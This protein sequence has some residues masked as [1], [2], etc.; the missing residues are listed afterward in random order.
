M[1]VVF[2]DIADSTSLSERLDPEEFFSVLRE[3]RDLCNRLVQKYGGVIARTVGDGLL[4]YFGLPQAHAD[5]PE[6]GVLA[7]LAI[8]AAMRKHE[9]ATSDLGPIRLGV[10]IG[11]NTGVLVVG[12]LTGEPGVERRDVFG[13]PVHIAARLQS[14]A[15]LNGVIIG[16]GTHDLVKGAFRFTRLSEQHIKGIKKP[17]AVWR[18]DGVAHTEGRFEKARTQPLTPMIGRAAECARLV[19]LWQ[20]AVAGSGS[21]AVVSG[22]KGIGKS[23]L[24]QALRMAVAGVEKE[25]LHFQCSPLQVNTPLAPL[26]EHDRRQAGI[27]QDD[28]PEEMIAKL[29]TILA[30]ATADTQTPIPYYG[31]LHSIPACEGYVPAELSSPKELERALQVITSVVTSLS[32]RRPVL[33]VVED[34]QWIDPT[35]VAL[36]EHL[37]ARIDRERLLLIISHNDDVDPYWLAGRR[38][39]SLPLTKLEPR[40][41]EKMVQTVAG[42]IALPRGVVR[43]ILDRA[44]GIPLFIEACTRS[45]L[46]ATVQQGTGGHRAAS[47]LLKEP[48]VP[49]SLHDAIMERLDLLGPA[50][51]VAQIASVFGRQFHFAGLRHIIDLPTRSLAEGLQSLEKAGLVTRQ[52]QSPGTLFSFKHAMIQEVAYGSLLKDMRTALHA[53]AVAWLRQADAGGSGS[54]LAVLGYHYSR[55]GLVADAVGAWLDAGKEALSRSASREAIANLWEG[56][57]LV[58]KLPQPEDRHQLELVLQA[59]LGMAYTAMV[60]WAGPQ[61]DQPYNRALELCRSYGTAREK[62]I[63]LWGV[64]IAALVNSQLEK[65][66][67]FANEFT[68]LAEQWGDEEALLMANATA[69]LANFFRGHLQQAKAAARLICERYDR[70]KHG[71]LVQKCQHDP[72]V[73]SLVYLGHIEWLLGNPQEAK[74]AC[75]AARQLARELG[76][77]FMLAFALILGSCDHLYERNHAANLAC[78]EEG[79]ELA[80]NHG[81]TLYGSFGPLW[82]IPA[83][84][85]KDASELDSLSSLLRTLLDNHYYLQAPLYQ[86]LLAAELGRTG[87]V[88]KGRELARAAQALMQRTGER[89]FEPEIYRVSGVLASLSPDPDPAGAARFFQRSLDSARSLGTAGWELRTAVSFARALKQRGQADK[90]RSLLAE[91]TGKFPSSTA[92]IDLRRADVLLRELA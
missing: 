8:A 13:T 44:D 45:V 74:A 80:K 30:F 29:H 88:A 26:I 92:S 22:G 69:V 18:V 90:A 50:K 2:I 7:G 66:L 27:E 9:F 23:R 41:C 75:D 78:V 73:V 91:V 19:D 81:L 68:A 83:L 46:E 86:I 38:A 20:E 65:A 62:A 6:N 58:A 31:A 47:A 1:T 89:W 54:R 56:L 42:E 32:R 53:R 55:A 28:S 37:M 70:S 52:R 63:V 49:P 25:T 24:I 10:R 3:Y 51:R 77:P 87:Q 85:A 16:P 59:H 15:P 61:V 33:I 11:I 72:K 35:S 14:S 36:L 34:V 43:S 39:L 4:A 71:T 67:E 84:A 57:D 60:G 76:H 40:E 48:V 79:V 64:T 21:A 5:D 12:S 82:A 17:T